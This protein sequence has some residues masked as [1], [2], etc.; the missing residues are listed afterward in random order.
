MQMT[1]E[2]EKM[3][4]YLRKQHANWRS[5]RVIVLLFSLALL[6]YTAWEYWS[7][8]AVTALWPAMAIS[9]Y[10]LSYALGSWSGRPEISLLLK[11]VEDRQE[12]AK[13]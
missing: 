7:G 11:L 2:E 6:G 12:I 5:T 8:L 3:V 4:A 10:G 9:C 13:R 1:P